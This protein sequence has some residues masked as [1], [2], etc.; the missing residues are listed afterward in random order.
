MDNIINYLIYIIF[1]KI[2]FILFRMMED[3]SSK[4][5]VGLVKD[6]ICHKL[7]YIKQ[8]GLVNFNDIE[9]LEKQL[10]IKRSG[11]QAKIETICYHHKHLL[12]VKYES[13]Q[14][15]CCDPFQTHK[16]SIKGIFLST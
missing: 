8:I 4:C 9:S 1:S 5:S 10:I 3:S 15:T 7:T 6:E 13:H 11:I 16:K 14:K 2:F 12:L